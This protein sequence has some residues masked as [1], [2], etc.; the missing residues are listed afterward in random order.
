[1]PHSRIKRILPLQNPRFITPIRIEYELEGKE[2][3]WEA[4][5]SHDS[6]AILLY[7]TQ[8]DAFVLVKQLRITT[9][10]HDSKSDGYTY[11]LCAG[12]VDKELPLVRIAQEEILEE[13]GFDV[14]IEQIRR[15]TAYYTSVGFSGAKQT[16]FYAQ[17]DE[18]MKKGPG[19]GIDDEAIEIIYLPLRE[20]KK[21]MFDESYKKTPGLL[22]AFYWF[23]DTIKREK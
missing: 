12:I 19:G 10:L 4:V 15:I 2:R 1:M 13:C 20:A 18:K 23:F 7:H 3:S 5:R 16:M 11:E 21:F 22:M 6:V 9:L 17:I 8:K 14:P